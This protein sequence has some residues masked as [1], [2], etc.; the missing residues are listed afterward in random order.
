MPFLNLLN[1]AVLA[2]PRLTQ[3]AS[4]IMT[5]TQEELSDSMVVALK[6]LVADI[7]TVMKEDLTNTRENMPLEPLLAEWNKLLMKSKKI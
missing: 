1:Q 6:K 7:W 3:H 4:P 2:I 5:K